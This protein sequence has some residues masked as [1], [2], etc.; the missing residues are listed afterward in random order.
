MN[1]T[2]LLCFSAR[3]CKIWTTGY[4]NWRVRTK[5]KRIR[6][7]DSVSPLFKAFAQ[8]HKKRNSV[9]QLGGKFP[10]WEVSSMW[11]KAERLPQFAL[12]WEQFHQQK[13]NKTSQKINSARVMKERYA[14]SAGTEHS[15]L[16]LHYLHRAC[17]WYLGPLQ[18]FSCV[19]RPAELVWR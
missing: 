5:G 16:N 10:G 9:V 13:L 11:L 17:L 14:A 4:T 1:M 18:K 2:W 8:M 12:L 3:V 6:C 15:T 19:D 7:R